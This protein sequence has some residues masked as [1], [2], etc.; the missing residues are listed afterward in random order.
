[1]IVS[2]FRK[3]KNKKIKYLQ[4]GAKLSMKI[5][6]TFGH[7]LF[8]PPSFLLTDV[9]AGMQ[10]VSFMDSNS[11]N[12]SVIKDDHP[13]QSS[14]GFMGLF[15][16]VRHK[17]FCQ[18]HNMAFRGRPCK[19]AALVGVFVVLTVGHFQVSEKWDTKTTF[20]LMDYVKKHV[21]FCAGA[22]CSNILRLVL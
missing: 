12:L 10:H 21:C 9:C 6:L 13:D 8:S 17:R 5:F 20:Q 3:Q 19:L 2:N 14:H 16:A 1:M 22:S 4:Q 7:V 11:S 18:S 15:T